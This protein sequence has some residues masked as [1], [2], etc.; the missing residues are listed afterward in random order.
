MYLRTIPVGELRANCYIFGAEYAMYAAVIDPGD[1]FDLIQSVLEEDCKIPSLILLTHAHPDHYYAVADFKKKYPEARLCLH[2]D[3]VEM[4]K[5]RFFRRLLG[6][7]EIELPEIDQELDDADVLAIGGGVQ[8]TVRHT[9][10]HTPGGVCYST[11]GAL[12]TG[13]T[14][15]MGSAGRTDFPHGSHEE[16]MKSINDVIMGYPD[17]VDVYP[18]HGPNSTIGYEKDTNPFVI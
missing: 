16:I 11:S 12:F 10:G 9:P 3:D 6:Y 7:R 15:F 1:Q 14:L 4:Y 2:K 8:I 17:E 18:G 5:D 13:D